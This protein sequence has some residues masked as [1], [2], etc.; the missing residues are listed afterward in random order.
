MA[1]PVLHI[2]DS[3]YFEVPK[4]LY[5]YDYQKRQQFPDV[6]VSLDPEFQDWEV[7]AALSRAADRSD[8]GLPAK[9][10]R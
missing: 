1:D 9:D 8:A 5:P 3:Y 7:R 6:W 4:V 2:K 10:R